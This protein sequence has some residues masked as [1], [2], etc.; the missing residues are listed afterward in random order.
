MISGIFIRRPRIAIVVSIVLFLAGLISLGV[1]PVT[2]YPE[3]SPPT[4]SVSAVYPGASAQ[5]ISDVVGG[6][7]EDAVNGVD[8]M[9]YMTSNSSN[10]GLYSLSVTFAIGTDPDIAQINVQNRLQS[11]MSQLPTSVSQ[12][13]VTVNARSPDFLM[14]I[15]LVSPQ[16]TMDA[17]TISNFASTNLVDVISRV[18]GV[19]E[20]SVTG[21]SE[22]SMRIWIDP[23]RMTALSITPDEVS[24]AIQSQNVQ[25]SLGQVGASPAPE[26]M[27]VEYTLTA[28][29]YLDDPA[30]FENIVIRSDEDEGIVRLRDIG[31]VELG[32]QSYAASALLNGRETAMLGINQA[33][34]SNAIETAE[35]VRAEMERLASTF[36]D[37]LEYVVVY[38]ATE[39]VSATIQEIIVTFAMTFLIV[40]A[41]TFVFLQEWRATLIP[42]IAV[43]I[44]LIGT[45]AILLAAGFSANTVTLLAMILAIGVV[46]DDA[47][48]V[49]ENVQRLMEEEG[50]S[51]PEAALKA[52]GQVT[53]PIVSTTLVLLAVFVPTAFLPG[54]DGQLYRQFAITLSA[55]MVLSSV[56]ALTLSP[57]L[58]ATIL[59]K[60]KPSRGPLRLF[61]QGLER[62]RRGYVGAV[63]FLVRRWIV[64]FAG[65]AAAFAVAYFSFTALPTTFLPDEDQGAIFLDV[66][67]PDAASLQRTSRMMEQVETRLRET[68]GVQN[69]ISVAGFSMLQ[70]SVSPNGG[71]ALVSLDPWS[72]RD[73]EELRLP[74]I[75]AGIQAE[76]GLI[77]GAIVSAFA[78]PPIP[79]L[80][81][82]GG[83][84][85]R[86]QALQGQDPEEVAQV[87]RAFLGGI[88][89][90]PEIAG[91]AS[92][93][94]ADVPQLFLDIDRDRAEALGL[95]VSEIYSTLGA[96]FGA[97]YVNDF[98]LEGRIFQVNIQGEASFRAFPENVLDVHVRNDA[99]EMVPLRTFAS[100]STILAPYSIARYNRYISAPI[101]GVAAQNVS[102][103]EALQA[104]EAYAGEELPQGYAFEWSGLSYQE[105]QA[106]GSALVIF[107]L[108]LVFAYLFLVAQYES[109]TL[110]VT[111]LLSL[112]VAAAGAT[113]AL[114]ALGLANSLYAQ[115]GIVLLIGLACKNAILIVEFAR[116][117]REEIGRTIAEAAQIAAAQRFRAV[118][119]TAVSFILGIVPLMIATGAGSG[120]RRA[121]GTTVFGGML[122]AT[123]IGILLIP[124]L[125]AIVQWLTE[126]VT[127]VPPAAQARKAGDAPDD[128]VE[129]GEPAPADER[130]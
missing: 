15:G 44:S 81:A 29:G 124:G 126:R 72:E 110:P 66:Q 88:N 77:P 53:G 47:I 39:F 89:Q 84:D 4:V 64:T 46:V 58:C 104:I 48:L 17:L 120:A 101:N 59:K 80:G 123:I 19:G 5:V 51:P 102:S 121:I 92:S 85:L 87:V 9:L 117:Q 18:P 14:A 79:G 107:G 70:G 108:A 49:V 12:Q 93:F 25:A 90:L 112:G 43:P 27:E 71:F 31:R 56:V 86:L 67:L 116:V 109:W 113:L 24:A 3:I 11:A 57:A 55:S 34:G 45:F 97:R 23:R 75:L 8:D 42:A 128:A 32:A 129:D 65:I 16:G 96:I 13:G 74:S 6:P 127:G 35:G 20:A 76:L 63:E 95:S 22:Y 60:P 40:V 21:T 54:I 69:V 98:T 7:I 111:I 28:R 52:M 1:I 10:A 122:A 103:G 119:M 99:G 50:L 114:L 118:I 30:A 94:N 100:V 61:G 33:P 2:Q 62:T 130:N 106:A 105:T 36:P 73:T 125:Y 37:D 78:P 38:D 115:I 82:V 68:P 91:A 41:V 83:F 26:G